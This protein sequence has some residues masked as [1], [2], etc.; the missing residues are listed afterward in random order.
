MCPAPASHE[1]MRALIEN[2]EHQLAESFERDAGTALELADS[3]TSLLGAVISSVGRRSATITV[4]AGET[5]GT[6][7]DLLR[8]ETPDLQRL[9]CCR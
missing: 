7:I 3:A 2:T 1:E 4:D 6:E 5:L 9:T 8:E